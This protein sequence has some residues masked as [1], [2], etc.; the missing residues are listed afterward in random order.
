VDLLEAFQARMRDMGAG[1][2]AVKQK[3]EAGFSGIEISGQYDK[4]TDS[5]ALLFEWQ[6]S[7]YRVR[8]SREFDDDYVSKSSRRVLGTNPARTRAE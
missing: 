1:V 2:E 6:D 5:T 7:T 4:N 3:L 8:I